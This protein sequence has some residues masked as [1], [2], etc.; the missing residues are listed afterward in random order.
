MREICLPNLAADALFLARRR[1]NFGTRNPYT[2][3]IPAT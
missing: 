2:G 1:L 3:C